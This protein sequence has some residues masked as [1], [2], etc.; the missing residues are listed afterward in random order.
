MSSLMNDALNTPF[1]DVFTLQLQRTP[2]ACLLTRMRQTVQ[3]GAYT[4]IFGYGMAT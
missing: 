1:I 2:R 4:R 3:R